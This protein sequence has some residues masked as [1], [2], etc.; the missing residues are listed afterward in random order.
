M[1]AALCFA[2]AAC[3]LPAVNSAPTHASASPSKEVRLV[4]RAGDIIL[5]PLN[6]YVCNAIESETGTP[7]SHAVVVA[8][9]TNQADKRNVLE[10]WG[11]TKKTPYS[12]I[13]KRKQKN[14]PLFLLRPKNFQNRT[15]PDESKIK[16]H[17]ESQFANLPFDD[18]YLWDNFD[19]QRQEKLYCT[20]FVVKFINA[21]IS[22]PVEPLPM[23]FSKNLEFWIKYYRQFGM[24][25]PSGRLGASPAT[26]FFSNEFERLGELAED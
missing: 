7:Y 23:N 2:A 3:S 20:E 12:D 18:E 16:E 17:F 26:L 24:T 11:E 25:P 15:A 1:I 9:T 8:D 14:Q 5:V 4:P 22:K 6:C 13:V 10:A 19:S 21:F